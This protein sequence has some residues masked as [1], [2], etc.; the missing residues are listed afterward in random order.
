V[1]TRTLTTSAE[2]LWDL[3]HDG[4]RRELVE[5]RL[6]VM[7]PAGFEHGRVAATANRLLSV[8]VHATGTGVTLAAETGFLLASDPDTVRAPDVAFVARARV[9]AAGRTVR[10][11]PGAPDF[12]L[13][14]VSPGDT[15]QE[16]LAK[17]QSWL[18]AGTKAVL[19][20]D[21]AERAATV[22]RAGRDP[23]TSTDGELDL[24]DAVPGWRVSVAG[25]FS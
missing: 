22:Y 15:L 1:A 8:H 17:A 21:P 20:L 25:F 5:G 10:F 18:A 6:L 7:S 12:A 4:M 9:E 14:V 3:P 19:V 16:V 24:S 23:Q 2:E 13:E 11:W